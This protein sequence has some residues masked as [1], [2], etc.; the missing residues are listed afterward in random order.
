[1][2]EVRPALPLKVV[3]YSDYHQLLRDYYSHKKLQNRNFS[4]R[5]FAQLAGIKSSNYLLLVMNR[6]RKL[7]PAT[8]KAVARAMAMTKPETD[9]FVALVKMERARS[10]EEQDQIEKDQRS[11][12]KKILTKELPA[13]KAEYL[14]SWYCPLV[15]ELAFLPDFKPQPAWVSE[16][17]KGMITADQAEGAIDLLLKL[18]LWKEVK[19]QIIVTDVFLDTGSEEKSYGDINITKIHKQNLLAWT[20]LLEDLPKSERELGL[21]NIPI[22]EKKIPELKLRIQKFQD[23]IIGW[24][25]DEKAPTQ[26]VQLGT[27]M[28][29]V[30]ARERVK[31]PQKN[32]QK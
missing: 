25:Q 2:S 29:P 26:L 4:F 5:R 1:M 20:A 6:Q 12:R 27:Y 7:L 16:K 32:R 24:L 14:R 21:L 3:E 11:A 19:N 10:V 30:T 8:A 31:P 22:D 23:E 9:Y 17:L 15:R 28:I 13:E 18:G